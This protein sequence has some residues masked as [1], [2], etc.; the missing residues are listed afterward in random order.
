MSQNDFTIA[1]QTFPNTRAD[2]NSAL[3]AL[4]STSS[5]SS[6]PSTTFA[7]QL[8]YNTTSNL[9]QIRNEDNDAFITIAELDQTNDTVEYVK[10][11][12]IR[13]A[14]IEF[15]D[16]DD[17]L[18]IADGGGL[19]VS[20]SLDMNG[21]E[22]IL[23]ADADTSIT[24]DTD[25]RIDLRVGGVDR[26]YITNNTIGAIINRKNA[27]SIIINGDMQI[28]QRATSKTGIT[29]TTMEVQDRWSVVM[30]GAGTWTQTSD[31]DVPS[32]QGFSKSQKWDCTTARSL[33]AGSIMYIRQTIEGQ[34]L[35]MLKYGSSNAETLTLSFWLKSPKTGT[36]IAQLYGADDNRS[37]SKAYTVSSANTWEKHVIN[38][39]ADTTGVIDNDNGYGMGLQLWFLAGTTYSSGTLNTTW[40]TYANADAAVGQVDCADSTSNNILLTGVQL[41][42]GTY[43]STTIPPF[44][45]ESF[46]DNLARCHRYFFRKVSGNDKSFASG[47]YY[48]SAIVTCHVDFPTEMRTSP[49]LVQETGTDFYG[50][51]AGSAFDSF[52]GFTATFSAGNTGVALDCNA[53]ISGTQGDGGRIKSNNASAFLGFSA[54]I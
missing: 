53:N 25:D 8:F 33:E 18:A 16:G 48:N 2:I 13:T 9:L 40:N 38:F 26:A 6:A 1:N 51:F 50:I 10:S 3:Q 14:L 17:A 7:N 42:I 44:Q 47:A 4:A 30:G 24:A 49:S 54:E 5:G 36:H 27:E 12:S 32:G 39:P 45:H 22:L 11:D 46:G 21:T 29:S 52:D 34:N 15:T 41:E 37:V 23:D 28:N 19:T 31:T 20:T 35:Q 43:D